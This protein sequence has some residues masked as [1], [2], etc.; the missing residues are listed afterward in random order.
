MALPDNAIV[1]NRAGNF[2]VWPNKFFKFGAKAWLL[3]LQ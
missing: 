2:T 3:V 1:T